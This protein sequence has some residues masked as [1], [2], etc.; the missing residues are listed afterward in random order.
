VRVAAE[1]VATLIDR[2][3]PYSALYSV[4]QVIESHPKYATE[5]I[6]QLKDSGIEVDKWWDF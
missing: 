1:P 2:R 5:A 3:S 6:Q 4:K